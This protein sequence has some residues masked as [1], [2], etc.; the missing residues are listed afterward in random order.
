MP[1]PTGESNR[2]STLPRGPL[3]CTGPGKEAAAEQ[4][5]CVQ[6]LGGTAILPNGIVSPAQIAEATGI[7]G[8]LYWCDDDTA[9]G[10]E[11]ALAGRDGPTP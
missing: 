5:K 3:L 9:R 4:V 1:G 2:L 7:S 6:A 10:I 11:I 8:V